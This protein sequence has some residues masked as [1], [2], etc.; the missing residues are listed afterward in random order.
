MDEEMKDKDNDMWTIK[1]NINKLNIPLLYFYRNST[2]KR[3][4]QL[5]KPIE[6]LKISHVRIFHTKLVRIGSTRTLPSSIRTSR[7]RY[8]RSHMYET[9][10]RSSY[11]LFPHEPNLDLYE[12]SC[13]DIKNLTSTNLSYEAR[14][15]WFHSN[16]T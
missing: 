1:E 8:K 2:K 14:T 13:W 3:K 16:L 5:I 11:G 9:F 12:Q 7:L 10:I 4:N 15:G 6:M